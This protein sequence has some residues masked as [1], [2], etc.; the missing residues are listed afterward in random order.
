VENEAGEM[1]WKPAEGGEAISAEEW[2]HAAEEQA[3]AT[4]GE[5]ETPPSDDAPPEAATPPGDDA[6]PEAATPPSD[7][8]TDGEAA[9]PPSEDAAPAPE[10]VSAEEGG[11]A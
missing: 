6:P 8:A 4:D 5:A 10:A 3:D 7:D 11:E 9:T 1:V 2:S